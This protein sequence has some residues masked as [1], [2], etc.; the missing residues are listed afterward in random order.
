[1]IALGVINEEDYYYITVNAGEIILQGHCSLNLIAQ[2]DYLFDLMN[3]ADDGFL[4]YQRGNVKIVL[5]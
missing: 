3:K 1:M 4:R 5:T 2:S